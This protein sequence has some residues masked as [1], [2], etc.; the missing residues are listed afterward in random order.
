MYNMLVFTLSAFDQRRKKITRGSYDQRKYPLLLLYK[1][2]I[3]VYTLHINYYSKLSRYY[4]SSSIVFLI[5][6]TIGMNNSLGSNS[7]SL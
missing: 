4:P 1:Y 2:N 6:S 3:I 7:K 5:K